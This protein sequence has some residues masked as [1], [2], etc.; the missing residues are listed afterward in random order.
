MAWMD[1]ATI[2]NWFHLSLKIKVMLSFFLLPGEKLLELESK[3]EKKRKGRGA[4]MLFEER[5]FPVAR[6]SNLVGYLTNCFGTDIM[7]AGKI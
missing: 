3:K 1:F 7:K 5:R 2:M 4:S 6:S